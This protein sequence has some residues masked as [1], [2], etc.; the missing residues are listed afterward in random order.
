MVKHPTFYQSDHA[1]SRRTFDTSLRTKM[2]FEKSVF[3]RIQMVPDWQRLVVL[4]IPNYWISPSSTH[5]FWKGTW[6]IS[7]VSCGGNFRILETSFLELANSVKMPNNS[8]TVQPLNFNVNSSTWTH[9]GSLQCF[10]KCCGN[11]HFYQQEKS[12]QFSGRYGQMY[13][14]RTPLSYRMKLYLWDTHWLH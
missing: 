9:L 11:K 7:M 1:R 6:K 10:V 13:A 8:W 5:W 12:R 4:P 3:Y 14:T 2:T